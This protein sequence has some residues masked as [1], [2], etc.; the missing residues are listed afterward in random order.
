M[1]G[2]DDS[3][4]GCTAGVA[5]TAVSRRDTAKSQSR[6]PAAALEVFLQ[7]CHLQPKPASSREM[8]KTPQVHRRHAESSWNLRVE[9]RVRAGPDT[10]H[11]PLSDQ[12]TLQLQELAGRLGGWVG[13]DFD[14]QDPRTESP[15]FLRLSSELRNHTVVCTS[16]QTQ[17]S[18]TIINRLLKRTR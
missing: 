17:N 1:R 4:R 2:N 6:L 10:T 8:S 13:A 18:D 7:A 12:S 3:G 9:L 15:G 16:S 14:S 11:S 5:F